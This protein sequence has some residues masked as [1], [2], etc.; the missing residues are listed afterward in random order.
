[1]S[2]EC[3]RDIETLWLCPTRSNALHEFQCRITFWPWGSLWIYVGI[4]D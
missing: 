4:F 1:M 2:L 3:K